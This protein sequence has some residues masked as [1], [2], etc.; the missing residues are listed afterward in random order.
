[1]GVAASGIGTLGFVLSGFFWQFFAS[2]FVNPKRIDPVDGYYP[3][4]VTQN[5]S[6]LYIFA[7]IYG[8]VLS[9]LYM[10]LMKDPGDLEHVELSS[11]LSGDLSKKFKKNLMQLDKSS[12]ISQRQIDFS[13]D[14]SFL[15][16]RLESLQKSKGSDISINLEEASPT[17]IFKKYSEI[18]QLLIASPSKRSFDNET[19]LKLLNLIK[20]EKDTTDNFQFPPKNNQSNSLLPENNQI[21]SLLSKNNSNGPLSSNLEENLIEQRDIVIKS[22]SYTKEEGEEYV[23]IIKQD[24]VQIK[25]SFK[26][27]YLVVYVGMIQSIPSWH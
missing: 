1:M 22:I 20:E 3:V 26:F 24:L 11:F 21:N 10:I 5:I 9:L 8:I 4:E 13:N 14:N 23:N 12:L 19:E 7:C 2:Y 27:W 25:K 17:K 15:K 18:S 6:K 16:K